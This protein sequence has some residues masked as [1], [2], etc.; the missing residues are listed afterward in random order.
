MWQ[1]RAPRGREKRE[2][3]ERMHALRRRDTEIGGKKA[4]EADQTSSRDAAGAPPGVS[5]KTPSV[6]RQQHLKERRAFLCLKQCLPSHQVRL[7]HHRDGLGQLGVFGVD[8]RAQ[9]L[10]G[11]G[12]RKG[13]ERAVKGQ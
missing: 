12:R 4:C 2:H 8:D 7:L 10:R 1:G 5:G 3:A 11:R 6:E 9:R 13:G